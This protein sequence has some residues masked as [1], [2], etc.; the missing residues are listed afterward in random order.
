MTTIIATNE[1][2]LLLLLLL[3][4]IIYYGLFIYVEIYFHIRCQFSR[5]ILVGSLKKYKHR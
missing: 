4:I 3:L 5:Q 2:G 1:H